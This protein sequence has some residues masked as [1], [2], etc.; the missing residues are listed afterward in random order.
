LSFQAVS[1]LI[2]QHRRTGL[3]D[4]IGLGLPAVTLQVDALL[5]ALFS[6]DLMAPFRAAV[7]TKRF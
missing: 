2:S 5:H 4:L 7:E 1:Q 6:E 3:L